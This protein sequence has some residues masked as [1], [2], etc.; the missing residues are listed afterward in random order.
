MIEK[1]SLKKFYFKNQFVEEAAVVDY[2][3]MEDEFESEPVNALEFAWSDNY[4]YY[5]QQ[6]KRVLDNPNSVFHRLKELNGW[7]SIFPTDIRKAKI[8]E[9]I[10]TQ[11]FKEFKFKYVNPQ[12]KIPKML[13]QVYNSYFMR[14]IVKADY[15]NETKHTIY[16]VYKSGEIQYFYDFV[17]K[18]RFITEEA[19]SEYEA[20]ASPCSV[21]E[22]FYETEIIKKC[23]GCRKL[24]D[25]CCCN[26]L[27]K[28]FKKTVE[29]ASPDI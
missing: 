11:I 28:Y 1:F 16:Y 5:F 9:E 10:K 12:S 3:R 23:L 27:V 8:N 29:C 7:V 18:Y 4:D 13:E 26:Q 21:S 20:P 15:Q 25:A 17:G 2:I 24:V 14:Q 22:P 19:E 6:V